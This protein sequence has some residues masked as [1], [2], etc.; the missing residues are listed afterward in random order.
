[1]KKIL[2]LLVM[3][4]YLIIYAE[5][6]TDL[7]VFKAQKDL[8]Q[9]ICDIEIPSSDIAYLPVDGKITGLINIRAIVRN[10]NT[11]QSVNDEWNTKSLISKSEEIKRILSLLDRTSFVLSPGQYEL[12]VIAH[13]SFSLKEWTIIDTIKIDSTIET[14]FISDPFIAFTISKDTLNGKFTKNGYAIVP[15]PSN[16]FTLSNPLLYIYN[17]VY[18]LKKDE[19]YNIEYDIYNLNDSLILKTEPIEK[20]APGFDFVNTNLISILALKEGTYK[21]KIRFFS[22]SFDLSK[23]TIFEKVLA[24][25]EA[26]I[27]H[28]NVTDEQMKYYSMIKYI[29]SDKEINQY[30]ALDSRGKHNFLINFWLKRDETPNNNKL[31]TLDEFIKNVKFVNSRYSSGLEEGYKSARGRIYL[32]YG[33]PDETMIIPMSEGAKSYEN[34]IYYRDSGMQFIFMDM[35]GF[36]KYEI[37]YT[38]V[39]SEDIPANWESYIDDENMIQF[40]RN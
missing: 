3:L 21:I 33:P 18:N 37:L 38:N 30:N 31:E 17:E 15:N 26:E 32:K 6:F 5:M 25:A 29:A 27:T 1:M 11:N 40:Y 19:K 35:K 9:I 24:I 7:T 22:D 36:G 39:E 16:R 8:Y 28:I 12:T 20:R 4:S 13:D 2:I 23:M 34:W 10:L 14:P